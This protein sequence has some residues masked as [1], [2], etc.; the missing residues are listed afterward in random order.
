MDTEF[1]ET[2]TGG[3]DVPERRPQP[4]E[5]P[6]GRLEPLSMKVS[7]EWSRERRAKPRLLPSLLPLSCPPAPPGG[8]PTGSW[9]NS[10]T[11]GNAVWMPQDGKGGGK[12]KKNKQTAIS[13][14][15]A[16]IGGS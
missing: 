7:S 15:R 4:D 5:S 14:I 11:C 16:E 13:D 10:S 9:T 2:S 12:G 6:P 3:C 8:T 1:T